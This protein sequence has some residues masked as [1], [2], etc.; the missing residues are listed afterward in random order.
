MSL[1]G[2][3]ANILF[4]QKQQNASQCLQQD[5]S[6]SVIWFYFCHYFFLCII[7]RH[8]GV[9]KGVVF[10]CIWE[11]GCCETTLFIQRHLAFEIWHL[12]VVLHNPFLTHFPPFSCFEDCVLLIA[13]HCTQQQMFSACS[14]SLDF[15][16]MDFHYGSIAALC[17][18]KKACIQKDYYICKG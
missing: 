9:R 6:I 8:K 10:L 7:P 11:G 4:V 15:L 5:F 2:A 16:W 3:D 12:N 13:D 18:P 1:S 17:N 14:E